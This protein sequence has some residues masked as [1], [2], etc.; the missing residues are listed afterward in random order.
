MLTKYTVLRI[1]IVKAKFILTFTINIASDRVIK[2]DTVENLHCMVIKHL[3]GGCNLIYSYPGCFFQRPDG[4]YCVV[5]SDLNNLAA[6]GDNFDSAL[7]NAVDLLA[8]YI[9]NLLSKQQ[10]PPVPSDIQTLKPDISDEYTRAFIQTV[11]VDV[12]EYAKY[13]YAG[14]TE[15]AVSVPKWLA[16]FAAREK[17]DISSV[18]EKYLLEEYSKRR[19]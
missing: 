6:F 17:I 5:F 14:N 10:K 8:R 18:V 13:F 2:T 11:N 15:T 16:E 19:K 3:K 12:E 7:S 4:R 9:Y 1:I